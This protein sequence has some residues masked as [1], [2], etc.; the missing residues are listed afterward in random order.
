MTAFFQPTIPTPLR[1]VIV[2]DDRTPYVG[3]VAVVVRGP[4]VEIRARI[5]TVL[6]CGAL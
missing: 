1:E 4:K 3:V 2:V 6:Q 5:D